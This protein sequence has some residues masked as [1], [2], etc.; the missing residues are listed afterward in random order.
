MIR[1]LILF[2]CRMGGSVKTCKFKDKNNKLMSFRIHDGKLLEK[3]KTIGMK[4]EE[5]KNIEFNALPVYD[6]IY[7]YI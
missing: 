3:C 6:D 4:I 1:P 2:L 5:L 7:I